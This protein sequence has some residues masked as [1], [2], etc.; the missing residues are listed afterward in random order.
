MTCT[1]HGWCHYTRTYGQAWEIGAP[2]GGGGSLVAT[3]CL[4]SSATSRWSGM[5][6]RHSI[7]AIGSHGGAGM[8]ASEANRRECFEGGLTREKSRRRWDPPVYGRQWS[9]PSSET[10]AKRCARVR[11]CFDQKESAGERWRGRSP[12]NRQRWWKLCSC[13]IR[14]KKWW[15]KRQHDDMGGLI[16]GDEAVGLRGSNVA[17]LRLTGDLMP[18]R[19]GGCCTWE[20]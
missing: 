1:V 19:V 7:V 15:G 2:W 10:L 18:A 12:A 14:G 6:R 9:T 3:G 20:W 17:L 8:V 5:A 16:A 4:W 13:G 11:R